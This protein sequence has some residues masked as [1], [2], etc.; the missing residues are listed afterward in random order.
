MPL[1]RIKRRIVTGVLAVAVAVGAWLSGL[2]PGLGSGSGEGDGTAT[3][4]ANAESDQPANPQ[5]APSTPQPQPEASENAAASTDKPAQEPPALDLLTVYVDGSEYAVP[6][7]TGGYRRVSGSVVL[8]LART[9]TGNEDGIRVRV[10]LT[11]EARYNTWSRLVDELVQI[12]IPR[13]AISV[14]EEMF[15]LPGEEVTAES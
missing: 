15:E 9:T 8:R 14:P 2:I 1:S 4:V 11:K 3:P 12:D 13:T 5:P 10:L 7:R 6:M